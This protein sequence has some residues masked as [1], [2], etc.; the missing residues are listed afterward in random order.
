VGDGRSEI[1]APNLPMAEDQ[2]EDRRRA[3]SRSE[4]VGVN[5]EMYGLF[6][7][8]PVEPGVLASTATPAP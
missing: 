5:D 2:D 7:R 8:R 4:F 3:I 6:L 1:A